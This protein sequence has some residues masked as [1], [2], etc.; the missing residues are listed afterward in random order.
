M[1]PFDE[2]SSP[3]NQSP[4]ASLSQVLRGHSGVVSSVAFHP[5]NQIGSFRE[6]NE[7]KDDER[8][9][10]SAENKKSNSTRQ[11][12]QQMASSSYDGTVM[13]FNIHEQF[14]RSKQN[15]SLRDRDGRWEDRKVRA[16]RYIGHR[17][18]IHK[19]VYAPSGKLL[20]SCSSDNTVRLWTTS[21][22]YSKGNSV[23]LKGHAGSVRCVDFGS[24]SGISSKSN[25]GAE[26]VLLTASDDKTVKLWSLPETNFVTSFV[27][28][29]NWVRTCK[30]CKPSS[31]SETTALAASGGDD[32]TVRIWSC[33]RAVNLTTYSCFGSNAMGNSGGG[34]R[35]LEFLPS[36]MS[37]AACGSDGLTRLFDLRS[38]AVVQS[39]DCN[40]SS[41]PSIS[42]VDS[43]SIHPDGLY[44]LCSTSDSASDGRI[45]M[46]DLRSPRKPLF[47][48]PSIT[49]IRRSSG[50]N[51]VNS[52]PRSAARGR[53]GNTLGGS[54]PTS[55]TFSPDGSRFAT[56]V[57]DNAMRVYHWDSGVLGKEVEESNGVATMN[58]A[59]K[60]ETRPRATKQ[61][62]LKEEI[63]TKDVANCLAG[64]SQEAKITNRSGIDIT[65]NT[66]P[67]IQTA[68][69]SSWKYKKEDLPEILASTLD[70]MVGQLDILAQTVIM[71]EQRLT[72]QEA[73]MDQMQAKHNDGTNKTGQSAS[74]MQEKPRP[75]QEVKPHVHP[76]PEYLHSTVSSSPLPLQ[77]APFPCDDDADIS[78]RIDQK[79][80]DILQKY[81]LVP[82]RKAAV[83]T[84]DCE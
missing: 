6:N 56:S 51:T 37:L 44:L 63:V 5:T 41:C 64:K 12:C 80:Q 24:F 72:I 3:D 29:T 73:A 13:I 59:I 2:E 7:S 70:R 60:V 8:E 65:F 57:K 49:S 23:Q 25:N 36:G 39:F 74:K 82:T 35:D 1:A 28:H 18:P 30:F 10:H 52:P 43:L 76:S 48:I 68:P 77:A 14:G 45:H 67:C 83:T 15:I 31:G 55:V 40:K 22:D 20:A 16:Y 79:V 62:K 81:S 34:V 75:Q 69:N 42:T 21:H 32:K 26:S 46:F 11:P 17:G 9:D 71:L 84:Q 61:Q 19:I 4:S 47:E 27:G 50:N 33:D 66:S 58:D 78:V 54:I 38:D 53:R